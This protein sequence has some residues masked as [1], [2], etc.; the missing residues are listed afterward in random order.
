MSLQFGSVLSGQYASL[1]LNGAAISLTLFAISW[2]LA[3]IISLFLLT[4]RVSGNKVLDR[5]VFAYVEYHRNIPLLVQMFVWYFGIA[6][7]LP[8][9]WQ[10]WLNARNSEFLFAII[11]LALNAAAYM[12]EDLR[13]GFRAISKDQFEA[14][15]ALG[16]SFLQA[17]RDVLMPQAIRLSLPPLVNQS[18]NLF[19]ATSLAMAIGVAEMAYTSRQVESATF[20]TFESFAVATVFYL[21]ISFLI[22]GFGG[23]LSERWSRIT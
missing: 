23:R 14:S 5:L 9:D 20:L 22:M 10:L 19:K 13:S 16:L 3:F 8:R 12:C 6:Q 21:M 2:V 18:L 15:R 7:L 11:A 1:F 17:M 4:L